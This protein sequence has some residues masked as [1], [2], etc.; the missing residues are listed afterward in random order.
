VV[1]DPALAAWHALAAHHRCVE[2][3]QREFQQRQQL[4]KDKASLA[5]RLEAAEKERAEL[6]RA[7][8]DASGSLKQLQ[9]ELA[10]L[11]A[12]MAKSQAEGES[13]RGLLTRQ[14]HEVQEQLEAAYAAQSHGSPAATNPPAPA[15]TGA[16]D[17][18]RNELAYRVGELLVERGQSLAGWASLP[19]ALLRVTIAD[20][21]RRSHAP[22]AAPLESYSDYQ[23]AARLQRH[24]RYRLGAA[25][26]RNASSPLG[27]TRMP[28]ALKKELA[29]FR[30]ER[31]SA[32]QPAH[33]SA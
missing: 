33:A 17:R 27:W 23:D 8:R 22:A 4:E 5:A 32:H 26:L 13:E 14:L 25:F 10:Q 19:F 31:G 2:E 16:A 6:A 29:S 7:S 12:R 3:H 15:P 11:R 24:L 21:R 18:V 30:L 1:V 28:W 9:D 20:R